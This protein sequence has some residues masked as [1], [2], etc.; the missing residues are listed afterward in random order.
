MVN[1]LYLDF[2]KK[3]NLVLTF[4][5]ISSKSTFAFINVSQGSRQ[6]GDSTKVSFKKEKKKDR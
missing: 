6:V 4:P 2:F 1:Q 5:E 3:R